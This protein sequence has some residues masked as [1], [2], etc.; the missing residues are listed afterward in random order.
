MAKLMLTGMH[1]E[2][3]MGLKKFDAAF[4]GD[5]DIAGMNGAGKSTLAKAVTWVLFN[6]DTDGNAP[7]SDA[8]HEKPCGEDGSEIHNLVT[9]VQLDYE[10]DGKPFIIRRAQEENWVKKRNAP[11]PTYTG[12]VSKYWINDVECKQTEMK[13]RLAS[14]VQEDAF[15]LLGSLGAFTALPWKQQRDQLIRLAD[16]DIDG[17]LLIRP[18]Y[19]Q[20]ADECASTGNSVDDVRKVLSDRRKLIN[21]QLKAIPIRIDEATKAVPNISAGE[22][23]DAKYYIDDAK[24]D[25]ANV[26]KKI[27]ELA[28]GDANSEIKAKIRNEE[29]ALVR[30]RAEAESDY[31]RK[32]NEAASAC[33]TA[34]QELSFLHGQIESDRSTIP[35]LRE[36]LA[37]DEKE[38]EQLRV[39]Y[40]DAFILKAPA[41]DVD[42]VCPTCGQ[43]L[44]EDQIER[45]R[46]TALEQFK[47]D[48]RAKLDALKTRG[49]AKAKVVESLK[50][51]L[52]SAEAQLAQKE[53][54]LPEY[55]AKADAARA[56]YDTANKATPD[57]AELPEICEIEQRLD[58][59]KAQ[60]TEGPETQIRVLRER[61][62]E[63]E[64][65]IEK[66]SQILLKD[67]I[68]KDTA[69]RIEEL[70]C[71]QKD[72]AD[73]LVATEALISLA[74]QFVR[75]RCGA[76]E[77]SINERFDTL[78][79][80]LFDTQINGGVVDTCMCMIPCES[81]L[82]PY[83]SANKAAR[84]NA[85]I[86]I[87]GVLSDLYGVTVPLFVD[88]AEGINRIRETAAQII[89][90]TVSNDP[91][92]KVTSRAA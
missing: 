71:Q 61:K 30:V 47:A 46:E 41:A 40:H 51:R 15:R 49:A 82:I 63:L 87:T 67:K 14:I 86:E 80:K 70:K 21:D 29:A 27:A 58:N 43:L 6:K 32:V 23:A 50:E 75:D 69:A 34:E 26:E 64:R 3:F 25:L 44:P 45:A 65:R 81:G 10:L 56:E 38:L 31:R 79:W 18:E 33:K 88:N 53:A 19:R 66:N 13:E 37:S 39:Q 73:R 59:L 92:L 54:K 84:T 48:R 77:E 12:N 24:K 90:L 55:Q 78:K 5:T 9:S 16:A 1:I 4:S 52:A 68:G 17:E 11:Q 2:N 91:E 83:G 76:L 85:D 8:F 20:L 28:T 22:L 74:E 57:Y 60:L 89:T 36:M 42:M 62:N 7:G 72:A 35:A